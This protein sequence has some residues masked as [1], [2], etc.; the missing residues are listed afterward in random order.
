MKLEQYIWIPSVL[1]LFIVTILFVECHQPIPAPRQATL[2]VATNS[3][4]PAVQTAIWLC[5]PGGTVLVSNAVP[6]TN[7]ITATVVM[8]NGVTL[9]FYNTYWRGS[10]L[11]DND[12][13]RCNLR[14][15]AQAGQFPVVSG[16]INITGDAHTKYYDAGCIRVDGS[17]LAVQITGCSFFDAQTLGFY[18]SGGFG[19]M[20]NCIFDAS[21]AFTAPMKLANGNIWGGN[22]GDFAWCTNVIPLMGTTNAWYVESSYFTNRSGAPG[23]GIDAQSGAMYVVRHC[24]FHRMIVGGHGT[25]TTGRER[26]ARF[27]EVYQCLFVEFGDSEAGHWR[28]GTGLY[29]GNTFVDVFKPFSM[30]VYRM[31]SAA[32][33]W[34]Y[35]TGANGFD[36]NDP[37]VYGQGTTTIATANG[38]MVDANADWTPSQWKGH[39]IRN[40]NSNRAALVIDN[41]TNT[42]AFTQDNTVS[43]YMP[44]ASGDAYQFRKVLVVLDEPG[45][46]AGALLSGNPANPVFWPS[47]A[48]ETIYQW[49]NTYQNVQSPLINNGGYYPLVDGREFSNNAVAPGYAPLVFPHPLVT[50]LPVPTN[51]PPVII[52]TNPPTVQTNLVQT[53]VSVRWQETNGATRVISFQTPATLSTVTT[54]T[55]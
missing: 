25:D 29:W 48:V 2:V 28:S 14:V 46:G 41:T 31:D 30:R 27:K 3:S 40:V 51:P 18:L 55:P 42:V 52:I 20:D 43:A 50:G 15:D 37:T 35:A 32:S 22:Y 11:S 54:N 9:L 21:G 36:N 6:V 1:L 23:L 17:C 13:T 24:V 34:G 19:V 39:T 12:S 38:T 4:G 53:T 7:N 47:N 5:S 16:L 33:S 44:F 26:G 8:T 45:R 10:V 49:S